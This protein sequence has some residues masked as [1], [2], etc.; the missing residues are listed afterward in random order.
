[1]RGEVAHLVADFREHAPD[2]PIAAFAD[3]D[4]Q[5]ARVISL[6]DGDVAAAGLEARALVRIRQPDAALQ[7]IDLFAVYVAVDDRAIGLRDTIRGCVSLLVSSPSFVSS[8]SPFE[9]ASSRPT[10]YTR[11]KSGGKQIDRPRLLA[12]RDVGAVDVLGLVHH[13]VHAALVRARAFEVA[14]YGSSS[15]VTLIAGRIDQDRQLDHHL[16]IHRD[17]P[18]LDHL[19][20]RPSRSD[21]GVGEDFLDAFFHFGLIMVYLA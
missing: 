2:L 19:F 13:D 3:R 11:G 7:L 15:T 14:A 6:D 21:T 1:M 10:G 20:H 8:S 12:L 9:S 17:A 16:P 18:L 4:L 5:R